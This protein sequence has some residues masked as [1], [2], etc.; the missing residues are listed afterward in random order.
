M[1]QIKAYDEIRLNCSADEVWKILI[2]IPSYHKW[3]PK[4]VN[5]K[6]SNFNKEIVNTQ[7]EARPF[8]GKSFSCRV[9]S[10]IPNNEIKL[11]YFDGIYRGEGVWKIVRK[12]A[13]VKVSYN[14]DL[15]I[16][17]KSI[18][19]LSRIISISKLHSLIFKQILKGLSQQIKSKS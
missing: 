9:I 5:L 16:V 18:A 13:S 1:P 11:N 15:E 4:L 10:I 3:W 17:D 19:F 6:V 2:D 8:G 7:F 12:D 14:V